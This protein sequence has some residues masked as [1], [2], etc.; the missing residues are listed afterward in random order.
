MTSMCKSDNTCIKEPMIFGSRLMCFINIRCLSLVSN[1][2]YAVLMSFLIFFLEIKYSSIRL[3][4]DLIN[5]HLKLKET[6]H[7]TRLS[8][9]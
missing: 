5:M 7:G 6:S 3:I 4:R 1:R 8:F 2:P 9:V